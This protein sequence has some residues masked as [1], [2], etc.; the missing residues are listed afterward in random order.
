M[1]G[2]VVFEGNT[3]LRNGA[4]TLSSTTQVA[5]L[6]LN[7]NQNYVKEGKLTVGNKVK[8]DLTTNNAQMFVLQS[9]GASVGKAQQTEDAAGNTIAAG[10]ILGEGTNHLVN[11]N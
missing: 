2:N 3:T 5:T 7:G 8:L 4:S 10:Q 1:A 6:K 9:N 11:V